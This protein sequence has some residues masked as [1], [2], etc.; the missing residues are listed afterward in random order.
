MLAFIKRIFRTNK[1]KY[2]I[3]NLNKKIN[4]IRNKIIILSEYFNLLDEIS[5]NDIY[6]IISNILKHYV[7]Y[8]NKYCSIYLKMNFIKKVEV[9]NCVN[10]KLLNIYKFVIDLKNEIKNIKISVV[11][12]PNNIKINCNIIEA[13]MINIDRK[14]SKIT[15]DLIVKKTMGIIRNVSPVNEKEKIKKIL[16]VKLHSN[17]LNELSAVNDEYDRF[18]GEV[19]MNKLNNH[20]KRKHIID[21][22]I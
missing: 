6:N 19:E 18:L 4:I 2:Y 5:D 12:F 20:T 16:N 15:R 3:N 1:I 9:L 8:Y 13:M 21:L 17:T 14:I 22:Y 11:E 7:L 10:P